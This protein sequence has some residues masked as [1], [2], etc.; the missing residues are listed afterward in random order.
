MRMHRP[1]HDGDQY[2]PPGQRFFVGGNLNAR[3]P[4]KAAANSPQG[5]SVAKIFRA[6]RDQWKAD[7]AFSSS[8]SEIV[9]HS[10]YLQIIG[11]GSD[12]L[13]CIFNELR[14][15]PDHWFVALE[16]ITRENPV[17]DEHAGDVN[18][19]ASDWLMWDAQP[20]LDLVCA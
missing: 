13:P 4:E 9:M 10:A 14:M 12:V 19:M 17:D 11:L 6:L 2:M 16:S 3:L 15:E 1:T 7:T 8:V 18:A 20:R 5:N